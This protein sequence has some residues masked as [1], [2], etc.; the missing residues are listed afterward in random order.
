MRVL[1]DGVDGTGK[2]SVS[3]KLANAIGCNIV[4]LTHYGSRDFRAYSE[5]MIVDNMVHDRTFMSE[6]IYPQ[7]FGRQCRLN[8]NCGN[9]LFRLIDQYDAHVFILTASEDELIKRLSL[10]GDEFLDDFSKVKEIDA[11][12]RT[13]AY[14]HEF[15]LIDTTHK[16]I[17][18]VVNE[19]RR[20]L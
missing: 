1:I 12:Y 16:T 19:I 5:A 7:Y 6:M 2:T 13:I 14:L 20:Y 11:E 17:D 4:R 3:E 9:A 15:H 8:G 18:Q 10:R